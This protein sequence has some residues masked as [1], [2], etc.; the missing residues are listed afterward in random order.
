MIDIVLTRNSDFEALVQ[1]RVR[2]EFQRNRIDSHLVIERH[3]TMF[4]VPFQH[5]TRRRRHCF[6]IFVDFTHGEL[7]I[8]ASGSI[9]VDDPENDRCWTA[10]RYRVRTV[11][12]RHM[13]TYMVTVTWADVPSMIVA[14]L[15]GWQ[16]PI[17]GGA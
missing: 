11:H 2:L 5:E 6:A 8:D 10:V 16:S 14:P 13:A 1:E 9:E 4:G 12:G 7:P 3:Q 15:T 17:G